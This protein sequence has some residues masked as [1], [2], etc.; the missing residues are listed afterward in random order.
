VGIIN[1]LQVVLPALPD[2]GVE[3]LVGVEESSLERLLS[4]PL[5]TR[6]AEAR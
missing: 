4:E 2:G 6:F 3:V 1:G 5:W